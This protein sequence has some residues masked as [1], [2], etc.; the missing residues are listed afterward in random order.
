MNVRRWFARWG[1]DGWSGWPG[2]AYARS[3]YH[4]RL[5]AVQTH[6]SQC[7]D[8]AP[9]GEV[10]IVSICAGDGRDV[11][12]VVESHRRRNEITAWL[13]ELNRHSVS[14][15]VRRATSAGLEERVR[16]LNADATIY[17]TYRNVWP[18]DIVLVCGVWGHVPVCD[19]MPLVRAIAG[20]CKSGSSVIWT[21]GVSRGHAHLQAIQSLFADSDWNEVRLSITP[22]RK[23]AAATYRYVGAPLDRPQGGRIFQFQ[24]S[25]GH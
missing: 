23:W 10:R 14:V 20:L 24:T 22:D 21:R 12:G 7:L 17:E 2:K 8:S 18:S 9:G 1:T 4:Q 15:G 3:G 25:A 6:L 13:V 19:R 5:S 11:I 16:Y